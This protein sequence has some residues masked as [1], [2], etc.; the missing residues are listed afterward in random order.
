M[1]IEIRTFTTDDGRELSGPRFVCDGC[2]EPIEDVGP[3]GG[4]YWWN[5]GDYSEDRW[6]IKFFH[7]RR[8]CDPDE[9]GD[10]WMD[11]EIG[12][13][14]LANSLGLT[15]EDIQNAR[16]RATQFGS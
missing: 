14:Y 8:G 1:P 16:R 5:P 10:S 6:P 9:V 11:L 7:K 4:M 12:I 3:G 13:V 15:E 2:E